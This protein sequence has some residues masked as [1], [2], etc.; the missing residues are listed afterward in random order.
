MFEVEKRRSDWLDDYKNLRSW[1]VYPSGSNKAYA[2]SMCLNGSITE[3]RVISID[4]VKTLGA[5]V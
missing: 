4:K 3:H 2:M 1:K 5:Q